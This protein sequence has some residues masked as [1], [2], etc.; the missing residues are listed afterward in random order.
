MKRK[1]VIMLLTLTMT[2]TY[3]VGC[4][5]GGV[6]EE[7]VKANIEAKMEDPAWKEAMTTP[8]GAYPELV[9][10]TL[11]RTAH[12][13]DALKGTEY[14]GDNDSNNAWTRYINKKINAQNENIFEAN[15]GEDYAQKVSMAI[16]SNEIP[17]I[18][19]VS[20]YETLKQLYENDL[21][22]DLTESYENCAS[23][24]IKDIY[25][26]YD[27]RV[28]ETAT[29]DGKLMA[30]PTTEISHGP[31]ILWLRQDWMDKLGLEPPK[32]LED[33]ENILQQFKDKNPGNNPEGTEGLVIAPEVVGKSGGGYQVNNIF[34]YFGAYPYQWIDDGNGK[35]I[36]GSIQP[37]MKEALTVLA[38][39]YKKGLIDKQ[40]AVRTYDDRKAILTSGKSGAFFGNWWGGWEVSEATSL[41]PDAKWTPYV[42]PFDENGELKMFTG[43]PNS[44]Y[45]VVRKG[46]EHPELLIKLANIQYDLS[47]YDENKEDL[48]E[49]NDYKKNNVDGSVLATNIDYYDGL[50]RLGGRI[51]EALDTGDTSNLN[52]TDLVLFEGC[53]KY[54]DSLEGN[55]EVT[56]SDWANYMSLVE[57]PNA[58]AQANIKEINPVFF[59]N[60]PSMTLK[61]PTLSKMEQEMYL[62]IITGEK[63]VDYFDE[64]VETW[65]KTGGDEITEEVN[66]ELNKK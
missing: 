62:K 25:N 27:G 9:T 8:Y 20:D 16:V 45:L 29:F 35:A 19:A 39:W 47:N 17:D 59:G 46:F 38:D 51:K 28:L 49:L 48:K 58:V 36:Y 11:G 33:I 13:Y 5:K 61:W 1:F 15:T 24:V 55:G 54:I 65:K 56:P 40:M 14:E 12:N 22:A 18:M 42:T 50:I 10:Y 4:G 7:E 63:S 60:T 32:T 43:N 30:L 41:N 21:I 37:E 53:K 44:S 66:Q 52:R 64:F 34:G 2:S 6:N 57:A 26:S 3:L 31:G 23:D